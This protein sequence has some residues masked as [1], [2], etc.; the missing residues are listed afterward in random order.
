MS[1]SAPISAF[2]IPLARPASR[3]GNRSARL[4]VR[5]T[6]WLQAFKLPGERDEL[7]HVSDRMLAD[8]GLR[9]DAHRYAGD[10][11]MQRDIVR[12]MLPF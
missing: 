8:I 4:Y 1:Y 2:Q 5:L 3:Q 9:P 11:L 10:L 7:A 12:G 6:A